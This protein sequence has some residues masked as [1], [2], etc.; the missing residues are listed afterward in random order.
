MDTRYFQERLYTCIPRK[1][2]GA[3]CTTGYE[4]LEGKCRGHV[5]VRDLCQTTGWRSGCPSGQECVSTHTGYA[6]QPKDDSCYPP[7]ALGNCPD[8]KYCGS[9]GRCTPRLPVNAVCQ[10]NQQ[11]EHGICRNHRCKDDQCPTIDSSQDCQSHEYCT[12]SSNGNVCKARRADGEPCGAAN[13]CSSLTCEYNR[14]VTNECELSND[15]PGCPD[16][17]FCEATR[18]GSTCRY[19]IS[20]GEQCTDNHVC[21]S[22]RCA[23]GRCIEDLC[24]EPLTTGGCPTGEFCSES[25][26][27]NECQ[28][29]SEK[30]FRDLNSQNKF[31]RQRQNNIF[32][33]RC[34]QKACV[35]LLT[36]KSHAIPITYTSK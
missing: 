33:F 17:Q 26:N 20:R 23:L 10:T 34:V 15:Y 3:P 18:T 4:C 13:Q 21:L 27:G 11:C 30:W 1:P 24:T 8:G 22:D 28:T 7:L 25:Q 35:L 19:Q 31:S 36:I 12:S 2:T 5:C 32:R 16:G 6:C 29:V 9:D 14:C